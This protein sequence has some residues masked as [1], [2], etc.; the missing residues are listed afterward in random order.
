ML[1]IPP[2]SDRVFQIVLP[3][4]QMEGLKNTLKEQDT[5]IKNLKEKVTVLEAQV[6]ES[7]LYISV[8]VHA[9]AC[10]CRCVPVCK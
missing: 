1:T 7:A 10:M 3:D 9:W 8:L 2:W 6:R 4:F 5:K